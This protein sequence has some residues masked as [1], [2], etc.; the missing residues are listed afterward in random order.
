MWLDGINKQISREKEELT[1][2]IDHVLPRLGR[3]SKFDTAL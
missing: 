1:W 2:Y 3:L